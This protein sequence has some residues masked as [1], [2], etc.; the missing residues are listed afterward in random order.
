MKFRPMRLQS[1]SHIHGA[2]EES[3]IGKKQ[4][5]RSR[6]KKS[7]PKALHIHTSHLPIR[8]LELPGGF[9]GTLGMGVVGHEGIEERI[10]KQRSAH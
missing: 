4:S 8:I 6:T 10:E 5:Q 3:S 1:S 9:L 2:Q 7:K